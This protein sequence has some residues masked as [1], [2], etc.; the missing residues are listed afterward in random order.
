MRGFLVEKKGSFLTLSRGSAAL[1]YPALKALLKSYNFPVFWQGNHFQLLLNQ[2]PVA[3]MKKITTKPG[4][5]FPVSMNDYHFK[6][7]AFGNR[8]NGLK[9][10]TLE[11][12]P[13][14]PEN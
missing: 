9:V 1:D 11:L 10:N 12:D 7:N 5:E 2:F 3:M 8:R 6:W 13:I 4:H 14:S